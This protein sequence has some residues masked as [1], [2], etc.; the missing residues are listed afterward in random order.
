MKGR[1]G[2]QGLYGPYEQFP[3]TLGPCSV[4][5][6]RDRDGMPDAWELRHGGDLDPTA[7][8]PKGAT[9]NDRHLGYTFIEAYINSLM[10]RKVGKHGQLWQITTAVEP[11]GSGIVNCEH[12]VPPCG[13]L[14]ALAGYIEFGDAT[15]ND[16]ST[17]VMDAVPAEG[18]EFDYWSIGETTFTAPERLEFVVHGGAACTAH[19]K[20]Q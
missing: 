11:E 4:E 7:V 15:Y 10:D 3:T 20:E 16:G 13:D 19:F 8:V 2:E 1:T 18:W 5:S 9:A 12:A 14:P 17:A 6:D